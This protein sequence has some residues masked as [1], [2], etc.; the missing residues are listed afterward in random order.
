VRY[1]D[2]RLTKP[3]SKVFGIGL[4]RTGGTSLAVA[5]MQLGYR[6]VHW[7]HDPVTR[8]ELM[9]YYANRNGRLRLTVARKNDALADTPAATVYR[10]LS[11]QYPTS[12]FI[13]TVRDESS[14]LRSCKRYWAVSVAPVYRALPESEYARYCQAVNTEVYG[15][16]DF[17]R[18]RFKRAYQDHVDAV[19]NWFEGSGR[20]LVLDICSGAGWK[21]LC[22]FLGCRPPKVPFPH[23][24]SMATVLQR[25]KMARS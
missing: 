24:N 4:S 2:W 9:S 6:C 18:A 14:W 10:E 22:P 11:R 20:L 25:N 15:V 1:D 13:L 3:E 7:P 21:E 5:L 17:D 19:M 12:R 8:S 23:L 16:P